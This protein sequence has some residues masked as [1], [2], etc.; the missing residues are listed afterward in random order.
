MNKALLL[1]VLL[2]TFPSLAAAAPGAAPRALP[3]KSHIEKTN[4]PRRL[5]VT[6]KKSGHS[7]QERLAR[8]PSGSLPAGQPLVAVLRGE[9]VDVGDPVRVTRAERI[10][11]RFEIEVEE[12]IDL[13]PHTV[14]GMVVPY[15]EVSL[16][17]LPAGDYTVAVRETARTFS[18][19]QHPEK[20]SAPRLLARYDGMPF[21]VR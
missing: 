18:D 7:A 11:N 6:P 12:R 16:G 10:G 14:S 21:Q 19:R 8:A 13:G 5:R 1:A 9:Q 3:L 2:V 4:A 20:L 17:A 15:V